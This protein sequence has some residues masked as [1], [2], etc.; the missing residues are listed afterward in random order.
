MGVHTHIHTHFPILLTSCISVIHLLQLMSQYWY[1]IFNWSPSF[2]FGLTLCIAHG[3]WQM[4]NEWHVFTV[5]VSHRIV[6]RHNKSP[7]LYLFIPPSLQKPSNHWSFYWVLPSLECHVVEIIQY[8]AFSDWL[9]SLDLIILKDHVGW[10]AENRLEGNKNNSRQASQEAK[11]GAVQGLRQARGQ[12]GVQ[13]C[14]DSDT[15]GGWALGSR[16]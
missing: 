7:V 6:A 8:V 2:T 16:W 12:A 3:F 1:I 5:T 9:L 13:K 10:F 15:C 11:Q 14:M 4:C